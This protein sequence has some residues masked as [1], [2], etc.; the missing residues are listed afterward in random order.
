MSAI[1]SSHTPID[2]DLQKI[3][4]SHFIHND[5]QCD[6]MFDAFS[7]HT[8]NTRQNILKVATLCKNKD[9]VV[10]MA[11]GPLEPIKDLANIFKEVVLIGYSLSRLRELAGNLKNV[12]CIQQN[13]TGG[14]VDQ[15]LEIFRSNPRR[16]TEDQ[17]FDQIT[18]LLDSD[19]GVNLDDS[20][21]DLD[22]ADL[23]ISSNLLSQLPVSV[24]EPIF[25]LMGN[26]QFSKFPKHCTPIPEKKF[27]QVFDEWED[28]VFNHHIQNLFSLTAPK[29]GLV[30]LADSIKRSLIEKTKEDRVRECNDVRGLD[31][32]AKKIDHLFNVVVQS[33]KQWNWDVL[34]SEATDQSPFSLIQRWSIKAMI[35]IPKDI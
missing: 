1:A 3:I 2:L 15:I 12:R 27:N 6:Q 17:A 32:V 14:V 35:I 5:S 23:V 11:P 33:P 29:K 13:F 9:R 10:I 7:E 31:V 25:E 26:T 22:G 18:V 34:L 28:R 16:Y 30:Y 24:E 4:D 21:K 8:T 20:L 19:K